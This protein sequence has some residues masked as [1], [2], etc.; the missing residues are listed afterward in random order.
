MLNIFKPGYN[1]KNFKSAVTYYEPFRR[2]CQ[3]PFLMPLIIHSFLSTS[4]HNV[5][6]FSTRMLFNEIFYNHDTGVTK[7]KDLNYVTL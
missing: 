3:S 6:Y 4:N 1:L 2:T 5:F 7:S